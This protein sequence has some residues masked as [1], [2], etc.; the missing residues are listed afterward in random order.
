MKKVYLSWDDTVKAITEISDVIKKS[1]FLP[2]M[3]LSVGRGGMIPARL[4][5]DLLK[6]SDV[7][8]LEAKMYTGIGTRNLQPKLGTLTAS[9]YKKKVLIVDDIVDSGLTLDAVMT[10]V[11]NQKAD[12]IK[13]ATIV[14]KDHV[15]RLP[16]YFHQTAKEDEWV[17]F[18]WEKIEN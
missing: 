16:S 1:K 4:L 11:H 8:M 18:P 3:I 9:V 7:C 14:I 10:M 5:S 2:D 12:Q 17:V 15:K 6:V 13:S